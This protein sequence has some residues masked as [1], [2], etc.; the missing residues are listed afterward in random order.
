M[1]P[2]YGESISFVFTLGRL[3]AAACVKDQR[4]ENN[5]LV[6]RDNGHTPTSADQGRCTCT[7]VKDADQG[8]VAIEL[9]GKIDIF[10][11]L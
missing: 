5:A 9:S 2:I 10:E 1:P 7:P 8:G 4:I 6:Q 11:E 3:C